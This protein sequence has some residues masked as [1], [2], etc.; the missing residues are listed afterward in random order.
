MNMLFDS[1]K[2]AAAAGP[3]RREAE[4]PSHRIIGRLILCNGSRAII[5]ASATEITGFNADTWAIGRLISIKGE[6]GRIVGIVYEMNTTSELW[7]DE[8]HNVIYIKVELVGEITDTPEGPSFRSGISTY[9]ALGSIA[10]RIRHADLQSIYQAGRGSVIEIGTLSQDSTIK[11]HVN[12]DMML[13]RHFAV[14]GTTGVGKSSAVSI[15]LRRATA[16]KPNLRVLILDPH[17]E[18]T[19]AFTDISL[20]IDAATLEL[21]FWLFRIDEFADVIFRGSK[22]DEDEV[23]IL[24][25]MV[26]QAKLRYNVAPAQTATASLIKKPVAIDSSGLNADTPV[27]YRMSDLMKLIEDEMGKLESKHSRPNMRALLH[28]L[29]TLNHE[30]RFRF[31]FS[32][33]TIDDNMDAIL[34]RIFRIPIDNK[35]IAVFQLAGLPSEVVNSVASVLSRIAFEIAMW[36]EGTY[37][38]LLLCEEAHRYVPADISQSFGPTRAAIAR[39]AKEGRKYGAYLGIVTQRPGELDPTILS[40]CSTIFA[41]RLSNERDQDIVRSAISDSSASTISFLSSIGNR[42]AITFGEAVG[43]PMRIKFVTQESHYLPKTASGGHDAERAT[44]RQEL[45]TRLV[46]NRM[47]GG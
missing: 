30:P 13:S 45:S 7:K 10:H 6:K 29:Q 18:Y 38:I 14:M 4:N 12:V 3:D 24:R 43:T 47:R 41:M 11:A 31:M 23:E 20:T 40:Q 15:L 21:P 42:E 37:E 2:A 9:P 5:S 27:P 35:P 8:S 19:K 32:R 26:T 17:N 28:R 1:G 33:S 16:A 39:I 25:E 34:S 22:I 44:T 46:I 36:S